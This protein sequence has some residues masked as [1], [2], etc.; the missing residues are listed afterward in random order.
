MN[1]SL[2]VIMQLL[3]NLNVQACNGILVIKLFG[4]KSST[5]KINQ[6]YK[7][8]SCISSFI[9]TGTTTQWLF[10]VNER[11]IFPSILL[12]LKKKWQQE[13]FF[14]GSKKREGEAERLPAL[15]TLTA[16]LLDLRLIVASLWWRI[17]QI[18][19]MPNL[20][21]Y[22]LWHISLEAFQIFLTLESLHK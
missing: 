11:V 16:R 22:F 1:S 4:G 3:E 17:K 5:L 8:S 12:N 7:P 10:P 19:S 20:L 9:I 18:I 15:Y 13:Q 2:T 6:K 14:T 21:I